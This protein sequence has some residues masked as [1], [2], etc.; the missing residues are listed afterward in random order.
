M[1]A[2]RPVF[3]PLLAPLALLLG[4]SLGSGRAQAQ[5][6]PA[7]FKAEMPFAITSCGQSLDAETVS[8]LAKR[9]KLEHTFNNVLKAE[10]LAGMKTLVVAMGGSA[11]GLGEAGID[12]KGELVRTDRLL[13]AAKKQKVKVIGVHIGGESRKGALSDKFI[14]PVIARADYLVVTE[15]SDRNGSFSKAAR[16]RKIPVSVVKKSVDVGK[17]LKDVFSR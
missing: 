2:R 6:A 16:E 3:A 9:N 1:K 4:I 12:E 11:K 17:A 10:E 8:L 5:G 14:D 7:V 15:D 13:E